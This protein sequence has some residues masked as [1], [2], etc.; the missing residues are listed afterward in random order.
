MWASSH[1]GK[2]ALRAVQWLL[3]LLKTLSYGLRLLRIERMARQGDG[4]NPQRP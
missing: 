4:T 2:E 1:R 3:L